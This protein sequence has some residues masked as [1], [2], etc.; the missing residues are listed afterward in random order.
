MEQQCLYEQNVA[1]VL[2]AMGKLRITKNRDDLYQVGC[3]ALW[4]AC[5]TFD[6]SKGVFEMYAYSLVRFA[7]IVEMKKISRHEESITL[8]EDHKMELLANTLAPP[9]VVNVFLM[10][11]LTV[12]EHRLLQKIFIEGWRNEDVAK[13]EGKTIEAIKKRRQRL[14]KKLRALHQ[15]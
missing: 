14:L 8:V 12:E 5:T 7:L 10:D 4:Q 15:N 3:L 6:C 1:I 13:A 2:K 9:K 11:E